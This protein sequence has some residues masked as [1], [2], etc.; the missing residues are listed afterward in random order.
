M[1]IDA[2]LDEAAQV[3]LATTLVEHWSRIEAFD[4]R[5]DDTVD[6]AAFGGFSSDR[7]GF[8]FA[9]GYRAA[10]QRLVPALGGRRA[11]L[12]ATEE[13][14]AHPRAIKTM[15]SGGHVRGTK[16][17]ATLATHAEEL[18][19]VVSVGE[20]DGRNDLRVA[21]IPAAREGVVIEEKPPWPVAPEIPHAIV[22]FDGVVVG[23]DDLLEGDGYAR[24]LKPFRTIEDVHVMAATAGFLFSVGRIAG[25]E[26]A[27][28]EALAAS[29]ASLRTIAS[30]DPSQR[31]TH[32]ALA[33]TIAMV[34]RT[35]ATLDFSKAPKET[36]ERWERDAPLLEVAGKARAARRDTAWRSL[37][38]V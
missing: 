8:A 3:G 31:G 6:R 30:F 36:R 14:G 37:D 7:L 16:T 1:I 12:C 28:L 33:G 29:I 10:L 4:A 25:W 32:V 9:T 2:L 11:C 24:Y 23:D 34:E 18:L 5:F 13:G 17:F 19:V 26:R 27:S 22:R 35:V 21:R 38:S 15:L 20:R